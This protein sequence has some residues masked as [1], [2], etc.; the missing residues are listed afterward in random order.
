MKECQAI[1]ELELSAE[2]AAA[3]KADI[4]AAHLYRLVKATAG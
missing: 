4:L 3:E 1:L 2:H